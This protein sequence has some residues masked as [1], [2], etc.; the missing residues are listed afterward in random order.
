MNPL[1]KKVLSKV[2][3]L[4]EIVWNKKFNFGSIEVFFVRLLLKG[5][6][7]LEEV[8]VGNIFILKQKFKSDHVVPYIR[9]QEKKGERSTTNVFDELNLFETIDKMIDKLLIVHYAFYALTRRLYPMED[10]I[11][12]GMRSL[13]EIT[14]LLKCLQEREDYRK[15][16]KESWIQSHN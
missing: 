6:I 1:E 10:C 2:L 3:R 8:S 16:A 4:G 12:K 14:I 15:E 5:K 7:T 13:D 11:A 9:V